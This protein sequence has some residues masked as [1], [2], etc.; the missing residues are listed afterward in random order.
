[1]LDIVTVDQIAAKAAGATLRK[2]NFAKAIS[3]PAADSDGQAA[4]HVTIVVKSASA[5]E[6][7]GDIALDLIV[8]IQR[9]LRA[10]GEERF[11]IVDFATE[12]ELRD[13]GGS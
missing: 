12:E 10:A 13:D 3:A 4:L 8:E 11:A 2:N 9:A 5:K 6:L 1:M 7:D